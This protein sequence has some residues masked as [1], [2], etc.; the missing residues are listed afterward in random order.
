MTKL[1]NCDACGNEVVSNGALPS[2]AARLG[3]ESRDLGTRADDPAIANAA[4][5]ENSGLA[6]MTYSE[7]RSVNAI[8]TAFEQ[9]KN[10]RH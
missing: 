5:C 2:H 7:G 9:G 8:P 6:D 1:T 10:G 4:R 3:P